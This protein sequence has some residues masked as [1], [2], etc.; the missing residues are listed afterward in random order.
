MNSADST[1]QKPFIQ[2]VH[3]LRRHIMWVAGF[4]AVGGGLG[5]AFQDQLLNLLQ[6]PLGQTLYYNSPTGG[7]AFL[8]KLCF[9][10]GVIFALPAILFNLFRFIEPVLEKHH[11]KGIIKYIIW[12]FLLAYG[13]VA[14][15]YF[16]SLPSALHFLAGFG[17]GK[18]KALIG[19]NEYFNFA[20]A[21]I[22]GFA[23]LF[24]LPLIVLFINRITPLKPGKMMKMQQ[25]VILGSFILAA[26]LTPTP[27]PFN[28]AMMAAPIIV[29]Y[30]VS[31]LLVLLTNSSKKTL[32]RKPVVAQ[33]PVL[34]E[35]T[36]LARNLDEVVQTAA[37]AKLPTLP[38]TPRRIIS[39]IAPPP[40]LQPHQPLPQLRARRPERPTL[41]VRRRRLMVGNDFF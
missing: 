2:H 33:A 26:I 3:E 25:Y 8:F 31:I 39:D 1:I 15:A 32:P 24:Q 35:P 36:V 38:L 37:P 23:V 41:P 28:Q 5:Y 11:R 6:K 18:V 14:F 13:G 4:V 34:S 21:Y 22:G 30:Q 10:T 40:K 20:I 12:S 29:L 16:I 7:I 9:A 17:D 27:D 19:A